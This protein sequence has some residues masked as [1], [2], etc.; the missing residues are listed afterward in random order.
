MNDGNG[1]MSLANTP[2][3]PKPPKKAT[4]RKTWGVWYNGTMY[5]ETDDYNT[6][7]GAAQA[8]MRNKRH[9]WLAKVGS[10]VN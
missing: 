7:Q 4:R 1:V 8:G 9:V 5:L 2:A 3:T 6:A 10:F